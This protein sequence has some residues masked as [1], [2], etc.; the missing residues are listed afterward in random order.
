[1]GSENSS[2]GAGAGVGGVWKS[3][4]VCWHQNWSEWVHMARYGLIPPPKRSYGRCASFCF[5]EIIENWPRDPKKRPMT[6]KKFCLG[7]QKEAHD[8][9]FGPLGI[10][11]E[12][13]GFRTARLTTGQKFP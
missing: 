9:E 7:V 1:M 3:G 8:S 10:E 2:G 5:P 11:V 12:K 13:Q 6:P 4:N